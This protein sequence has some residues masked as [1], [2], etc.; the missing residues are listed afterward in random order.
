MPIILPNMIRPRQDFPT[1]LFKLV[2]PLVVAAIAALVA[3]L[4]V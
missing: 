2:A 4:V 3:Y 1:A